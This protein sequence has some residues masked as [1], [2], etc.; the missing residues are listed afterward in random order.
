MIQLAKTKTVVSFT[1][2]NLRRLSARFN[3]EHHI[4]LPQLIEPHLLNLISQRLEATTFS[5][6]VYKGLGRDLCPDDLR[7]AGSLNFLCNRPELLE[8]I[9]TV[10]GSGHLGCF[11]GKVY[12]MT[13]GGNHYDSWHDD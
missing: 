7:I 12:R 1:A 11:V 9:E 2:E 6:R 13:P 5:R 10:T 4:I 8:F 3:A